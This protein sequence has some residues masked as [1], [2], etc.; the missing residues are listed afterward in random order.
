M[1]ARAG[2]FG[3]L[4]SVVRVL[5][6]VVDVGVAGEV[7]DGGASMCGEVALGMVYC[8]CGGEVVEPSSNASMASMVPTVGVAKLA[9]KRALNNSSLAGHRLNM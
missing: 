7:L 2:V 8:C 3:I 6:G 1:L 9:G 4:G 5:V